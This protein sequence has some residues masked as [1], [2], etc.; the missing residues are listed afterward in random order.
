MKRVAANRGS[1]IAVALVTFASAGLTYG[2][3]G[4]AVALPFYSDDLKQVLWVK[5][6]PLPDI[7]RTV[8]PYEH[9][10]PFQFTLWRLVYLVTGD[11]RPDVLHALN[12]FSHAM[13]GVLV[14]LLGARW[15]TRSW[16]V[17]SLVAALF[18]VFPFG[19]DAI[20]WPCALSYPLC[21][22]LVLAAVLLYLS[23]RATGSWPKHLVAMFLLVLA[24]FSLEAGVVGGVIILMVEIAVGGRVVGRW[25]LSY[26]GVSAVPLIPIAV[27]TPSYRLAIQHSVNDLAMVA[28]VVSFPVAPLAMAGERYGLDKL[29]SLLMIGAVAL[30]VL[31]YGAWRAGQLRWLG[32]GLAWVLVWVSVPLLTQQFDWLRDPP[33]IFYPSAAGLALAWGAGLLGLPPRSLGGAGRSLGQLLLIGAIV[34]ALFFLQGRVELYQRMGDVLWQAISTAGTRGTTLFVNVPGR[35]TPLERVYP[36]GHEGVIPLPPPSNV[37]LLVQAHIGLSGMA[38]ERLVGGLVPKLPYRVEIAGAPLQVGDLRAAAQVAVLAYRGDRLSLEVAG[39]VSSL[40]GSTPAVARFGDEIRLLSASAHRDGRG[41]VVLTTEWQ[42]DV[43][44][45][46]APTVFAHLLGPRGLLVAQADGPPLRGLYPFAEWRPGEV[47]RDVRV[48]DDA[49][50]GGSYVSFGVWDPLAGVRWPAFTVTG[51]RLPDDAFQCEVQGR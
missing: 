11:L 6:T 42:A 1:L 13:C 38:M 49:G 29:T 31:T 28:Q 39:A 37:D 43:P 46:G 19:F 18:V 8:N 10:R 7:W 17:P 5:A 36:L 3:Y 20:L 4:S 25:P 34:P 24:G 35:I 2:I 12:L 15:L 33:R 47:V 32:I 9:Y 48:F 44:V 50:L 45:E 27:V 30:A 14:G 22:G 41:N 26:L 40:Q 51:D 21:V 23:A 16:L